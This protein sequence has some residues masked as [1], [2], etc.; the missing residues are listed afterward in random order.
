MGAE[1]NKPM[2]FQFSG[3]D[4]VWI[5]IDDVLVLDLGGVHSEIYGII[6]FASGDVLIGR[7][8]NVEGI[9]DYD[10]EHPENTQDLVTHTN[11]RQLF[12]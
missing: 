2:T 9:P 12:Q 7:G 6:D 11:L 1:G 3:D 10:P 5:Y 8:F 4:D